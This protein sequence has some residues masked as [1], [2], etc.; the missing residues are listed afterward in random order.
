MRL[1]GVNLEG[2]DAQLPQLRHEEVAAAE[3]SL[4]AHREQ[5]RIAHRELSLIAIVSSH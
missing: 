1:V 3:R 2:V 5:S 4:I